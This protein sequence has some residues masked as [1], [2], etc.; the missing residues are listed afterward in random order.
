MGNGS[1]AEACGGR[2]HCITAVDADVAVAVVA[3]VAVGDVGDTVVEKE[4]GVVVVEEEEEGE[5]KEG[6]GGEEEGEE[7]W[8]YLDA[9]AVR[10]EG[11]D[12]EE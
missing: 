12:G 1:G 10:G 11:W 6:K 9:G 8:K 4:E 5:V 2:A 7:K 3:V